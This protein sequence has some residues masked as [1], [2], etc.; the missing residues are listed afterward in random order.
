[1]EV[2]FDMKDIDSALVKKPVVTLGTFDGVH[3]G[4]RAII[5]RLV[6]KAKGKGKKSLLV[7]YEPHPQSVVAPESAPKILTTLE[8]KLF[9]L[10]KLDIDVTVVINFDKDLARHEA[11]PFVEEI[12]IK[13]LNVGDLV[14]GYDHA[15]GKNRAGRVEFLKEAEKTYG[16]GLEIISPV[17][18]DHLPIKSSRIR[19]EL[20]S[21]EFHK[22]IKML[23]HS[24]PI[25]GSKVQGKGLGVSMGYPTINLRVSPRKL[26]PRDGVYAAT[27]EIE[28]KTW[29]GMMY[30]GKKPTFEGKS[31]S[32]EVHLFDLDPSLKTERVCLFVEKWIRGDLKFESPEGL[33]K[34]IK[35]DEKVIK[36]YFFKKGG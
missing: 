22:V 12:L 1:M 24:F 13:R 2:C 21:G 25:W 35:E 27:A 16:F 6:K 32:L 18:N 5:E 30:K 17:K 34:Q 28:G 3:L 4:H 11:K 8:E 15:F 20:K 7:T 31:P 33:K 19:E 23:G 14:I 26:L 36:D 29:A 9:F 10:E